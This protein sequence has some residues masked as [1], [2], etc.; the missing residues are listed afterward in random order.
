MAARITAQHVKLLHN[1][2]PL[3]IKKL[4]SPLFQCIYLDVHFF[5][6]P[7][8]GSEQ[9]Q[10]AYLGMNAARARCWGK[11]VGGDNVIE[12]RGK[13]IWIW[14]IESYLRR[15]N[16]DCQLVMVETC[17]LT[18]ALLFHKPGFKLPMWIQLALDSSKS[19]KELNKASYRL[20][21]ELPRLIRKHKLGY[22]L[23]NDAAD[24]D[25]FIDQMHLPFIGGRHGDS[26]FYS[27]RENIHKVFTKS[28]L[29]Y[30]TQDGNRIAGVMLHYENGM[31]T[32]RYSGVKDN[33][34][35]YYRSGCV[36]CF[37]YYGLQL[38][39][40]KAM[41]CFN[42]G[43]SSPFLTDNITY[44]KLSFKPYVMENTYL[45][46]HFV[47]MMFRKQDLA[48]TR[49]LRSHPFISLP[50]KNRFERHVF[51]NAAAIGSAGEFEELFKKIQCDNVTAT[52]VHIEG[53]VDRITALASQAT[54]VDTSY[55]C[56][57]WY[58]VH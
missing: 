40:E 36:G 2:L 22:E 27:S 8:P 51:A 17:K 6:S 53:D 35:E 18:E 54:T 57:K 3:R 10:L 19:L 30:I 45:D 58:S 13:R 47:K 44:F 55:T 26:A 31:A 7:T 49:F 56:T 1:I 28:D 37:Y 25:V 42:F 11:R 12:S 43:G 33:R 29:I 5:T 9:L 34:P 32:L 38:A 20:E 39:I 46:N 15:S 16:P 50:H 41:P 23:S 48:L 21:G 52:I 14:N 24:V 4:F